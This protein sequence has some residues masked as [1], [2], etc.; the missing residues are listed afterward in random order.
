MTAQTETPARADIVII[1]GGIMGSS[2][3]WF[4][5]QMDGFGGSVV[6]VER[7]PT[8]EF[9]STTHTNSCIRQQFSTALNIQ[10]SQ[11]AAEF[12][13]SLRERMGNNPL[14]PELSIQSF[15]YMYLADTPA[16]AQTLRD[17]QAIQLAHGAETRL[18]TPSEIKAEHPFYH[19]DDILLGSINRKDEGYWDGS[20]VFDWFKRDAKS[21][22][23]TYLTDE[24]VAI[25]Q[26]GA[27]V[28]S[29][30]LASGA[31]IACG[32]VVNAAG[33]RAAQV[34]QMV[35][36]DLP[37]EPRKRHTW[38]FKA[39][40]P[41]AQELPLTIDPSGVH[42]R[43]NNGG[44]YLAGG[45]AQYDPGVE[46]T[47]FA[48]DHG[49]WEDKVWPAL[50][51]RIPAFEAVKVTHA[52]VGHY[53]YNTLDHNAVLGPHPALENFHFLNGFSGH[54]LQQSPAMGRGMAELLVHGAYRSL[55]LSPF[56]MDRVLS[57]TPFVETAVI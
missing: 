42:V 2:T 30:T 45:H 12:V 53:A 7:D 20:T 17:N 34:A 38:I 26:T 46:Y 55:D 48:M 9:A 49:L 50:A 52:W 18:L 24:V 47:D 51:T 6:V 21:N 32:S 41:L 13:K 8:Y 37:V 35:G 28:T 10:I 23:V 43:E 4:L 36:L 15:G 5:S 56:S 1:G 19:V 27:R 3:A 57:E 14:V 39:A 31:R 54:G 22:G 16:F 11:F 25:E 44:T 40:H 33:P 29:V